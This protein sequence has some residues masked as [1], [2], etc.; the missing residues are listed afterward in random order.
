[1][2]RESTIRITQEDIENSGNL[3]KCGGSSTTRLLNRTEKCAICHEE[4]TDYG[5][6]VPDHEDPKGMGGAWR[7]DHPDKH[8]G[9]SLVVH[10][11]KGSTRD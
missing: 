5:G 11:E 7:D 4:F 8:S 1:M 3:R 10:S 9:Y 6:V 2:F